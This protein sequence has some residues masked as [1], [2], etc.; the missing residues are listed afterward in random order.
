MKKLIIILVFAIVCISVNAQNDKK[1]TTDNDYN[2]WSIELAAGG[3]KPQ[4]PY[5][6]INYYT[7]T[8]SPYVIDLGI[9][10]MLNNKF[11]IKADFGYNSFKP[12]TDSFDFNTQYYRFDIQG[13]ANLGRIMNFESWTNTF[14]LLGHTGFGVGRLEDKN[15]T[16][17]ENMGNYIAGVTAQIKLSNRFALTGDFT[18]I[19]NYS[20]DVAFDA[21]SNINPKEFNGVLYNGTIGITYY[22]GKNEKHADWV[23]LKDKDV[24]SLE[25]EIAELKAMN[26]D[27][28]KDGVLD[29][30]DLEPNTAPGKVVD[31]KGRT[32][33][34]KINTESVKTLDSATLDSE[35][36][37][38]LVNEGYI[39]AF[40]DFDKS[41]PTE[42]SKFSVSFLLTYLKNNPSA[43]VD[44]IGHADEI[45]STAYN[46]KLSEKRAIYIKNILLN[47]NVA[48]S[49]LNIVAA[50]EEST[51]DQKTEYARKLVRKVTYK[52]K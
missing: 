38:K 2:K 15:S 24:L 40:F 50:G 6:S 16:L 9:R 42:E 44:I 18:T 43:T 1:E 49:R 19:V 28:D 12:N 8:P 29:F 5:T 46:I 48:E 11:G 41:T 35:T 17:N 30:L 39:C 10:Y 32:I 13:V 47:L 36:I 14:G 45:G 31:T 25:G 51:I 23:V 3:N 4:R 7:S 33:K 22:I 34:E 21:Q 52:L 37:K 27:S 20:Q 26:V